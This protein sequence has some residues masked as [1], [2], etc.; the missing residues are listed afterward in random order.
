MNHDKTQDAEPSVL[1]QAGDAMRHAGAQGSEAL[2]HAAA[3]ASDLTHQGLRQGRGLA[4]AWHD[5]ARDH[6]R[7][8]PMRSVALAAGGG[9]ILALLVRVLGR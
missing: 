6:I 4:G 3:T 2:R 7:S 5:G 1:E 8:H 9:A